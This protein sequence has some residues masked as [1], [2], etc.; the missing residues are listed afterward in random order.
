[1]LGKFG[2]V[3]AALLLVL[4]CQ[5]GFLMAFYELG[6]SGEPRDA[7]NLAH[8]VEPALL[9]G[10]LP[11]IFFASLAFAIGEW[12]RRPLI[13]YAMPIG[14]VF[15]LP[16]F[17]TWSPPGL[18]ESANSILKLVDPSGLR[19]LIQDLLRAAPGVDFVNQA[20][21]SFDRMIVGNRVGL[22]GVS[23]VLIFCTTRHHRGVVRRGGVRA[24]GSGLA[25]LF[26][27]LI[28]RSPKRS[29]AIAA[30]AMDGDD[31]RGLR[32]DNIEMTSSPPGFVRGVATLTQGEL[33]DLVRQPALYFFVGLAMF[34]VLE[35]GSAAFGPFGDPLI[36]TA[37][38]MAV[39][40]FGVLTFVTCAVLLFFIV[41]SVLRDQTAEVDAILYACPVSTAALLCAKSLVGTFVAVTIVA[42]AF[43]VAV[44]HLWLQPIGAVEVS[45][46]LITWGV[47]LP[48]TVLV[49]TCFVGVVLAVVRGRYTTYAICISALMATALYQQAGKLTWL[50]NWAAVGTLRWSDMGVF[51]LNRAALWLNR[52]FVVATALLLGAVALR[53]FARTTPDVLRRIADRARPLLMARRAA[54]LAPLAVAPVVLGTILF[55]GVRNGFQGTA[56]T[57]TATNYW[58]QNLETWGDFETA[59]I[60]RLDLNVEL[61]PNER[62]AVVKG[63]YRLQNTTS[64]PMYHLPFTGFPPVG[65]IDWE[66]DGSAI[67]AENRTGLYVLRSQPGVAPGE[68]VTVGFAFEARYPAGFTRNGGGT[69]QFV[70]PAGVMLHNLRNAFIPVPG[71]VRGIGITRN[72]YTEPSIDLGR[73][74]TPQ[75]Q[76]AP[77]TTRITVSAPDAYTVNSVGTKVNELDRNGRTTVV[78]LSDH[79]VSALNVMAGRWASVGDA[80]TAVF[81]HPGH[82]YNAPEMLKTLRAARRLYSEWFHPYPWRELRLSE[83]PNQTTNAIGFPTNIAFSEGLGFL[84]RPG[85]SIPTHVVVTAHEAAHQWWGNLVS[86]ATGPGTGH[87]VEGMATYASLLL[88]ENELGP[89][90]RMELARMLESDYVNARR[91]GT[92]RPLDQMEADQGAD[93][94]IVFNKGAWVQ[95]M[96]QQEMGREQMFAALRE[97]VSA[98]IENPHR[99]ALPDLLSSLRTHAPDVQVFDEFVEQWFGSVALPEFRLGGVRLAGTPGAWR[100][101][102]RVTNA[103]TGTVTVDVAALGENT[104]ERSV[105]QVTLG[106]GASR[107]LTWTTTF[108]PMRLQVDPEVKVLQAARADAQAE[109]PDPT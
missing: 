24:V 106:P 13:V 109:L 45:P 26:R 99:P 36:L 37:G 14:L 49:W 8:Y 89:T 11:I 95:W 60:R 56:A 104:P 86:A 21:V 22:L 52:G 77:Y 96:L 58:R 9:F 23:V 61:H 3:L 76:V 105:V 12:T 66:M 94:A 19:W 98:S 51:E 16:F 1:M 85:A 72:N 92:E 101:A 34:M 40:I 93:R 62:R 39:S 44:A 84:S 33:R 48:P 2:G 70:L 81:F 29:R 100:V 88:V 41:E 17:A 50:T 82:A 91:N 18:A 57:Q 79:P 35:Q 30:G 43:L 28:R 47:L 25:D 71:F 27:K 15:A 65:Q 80:E 31:L 55:V 59:E 107:D 87:L 83:Y 102:A 68:F 108:R 7:F 73:T 64:N 32:L 46:L 63:R 90:S 20:P 10:A 6:A 4:L 42:S 54:W 97:F 53:L 5:V 78:W 38:S 74:P 67:D 103:G 75:N 69:E